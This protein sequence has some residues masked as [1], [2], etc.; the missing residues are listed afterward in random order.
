M[1]GLGC[2]SADLIDAVTGNEIKSLLC[3]II[4]ETELVDIYQYGKKCLSIT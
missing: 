1:L 3:L 4:P 2:S